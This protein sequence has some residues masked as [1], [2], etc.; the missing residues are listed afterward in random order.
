MRRFLFIVAILLTVS[1]T[2]P[3]AW[4]VW[5]YGPDGRL[6]YSRGG[7]NGAGWG[8]PGWVRSGPAV[9]AVASYP[10]PAYYYYYVPPTGQQ[11]YRQPARI[12]AVPATSPA[13]LPDTSEITELQ[14]RARRLSEEL[15]RVRR[16]RDEA[17]AEL[18]MWTGL[19]ITREQ[20]KDFQAELAKLTANN[21]FL[22]RRNNELESR[23][24]WFIGPEKEVRMP[25]SLRGQVVAVDPKYSF[26]VLNIGE[27]Q[28]IARDGKLLIN[29]NGKLVGKLRVTTVDANSSIA[30]IL[31]DWKVAE[32]MEGDQVIHQ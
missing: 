14:K 19:G 12:P 4:A 15:T 1:Q 7:W 28:G 6:W 22:V 25:A 17:Q 11:F 3:S 24:S 13:T 2:A 5:T 27:K 31:P 16:E 30:N 8:R 26:V 23:I 10:P 18:A 32:V 29:R 21:S 20:I 9:P